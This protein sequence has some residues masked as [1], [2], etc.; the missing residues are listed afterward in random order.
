MQVEFVDSYVCGGGEAGGGLRQLRAAAGSNVAQRSDSSSVALPSQRLRL[1]TI[2]T[3]AAPP[4]PQVRAL[5][6]KLQGTGD[7]AVDIFFRQVSRFGAEGW[8]FGGRLHWPAVGM[9]DL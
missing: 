8:A 2:S 3:A 7:G 6:K 9:W 4:P 1:E 5:L